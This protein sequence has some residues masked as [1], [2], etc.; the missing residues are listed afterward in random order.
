MK[1]LLLIVSL[2]LPAVLVMAQDH[3]VPYETKPLSG[4][5]VKNIEMQTAG[6]SLSVFASSASEARLEIYIV[7]NNGRDN[8]LSKEEIKARLEERY[9]IEVNVSNNKLTAIARQKKDIKDWKRGLSISFKAYVPKDVSTNLATSG[10]SIHINGVT[11]S[12]AFA[13]SGGSLHVDGVSG[14]IKGRT[15]GGSIHVDNSTDDI[16]LQTSGGS[17]HAKN[18]SGKLK[19]GTSGGTVHLNDLKGEITASTSGGGIR[20]ESISGDLVAH[21]S[22]GGIDFK[23]LSCSLETSTSG[24]NID[25]AITTLGKFVKIRSSGGNISLVLPKGKGMNLDIV[26]N[27]INSGA[28]DNFNGTA[29]KD[30]IEGKVNGGGVPVDV[31]AANGRISLSLASK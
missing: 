16:D 22:G 7:G 1:K 30:E 9:E 21:T 12:Q 18:C 20:G 15:S 6:G 23:N 25:V 19:L 24:G 17:I 31:R 3:K 29:N 11:G 13:T 28:L 10:G 14:K 2:L 8:V 26:G 27:R 5:S 4:Q